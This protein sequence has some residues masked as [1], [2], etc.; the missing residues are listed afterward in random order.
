MIN[1]LLF[2]IFF[3]CED[4]QSQDQEVKEIDLRQR[5]RIQVLATQSFS[6][7]FVLEAKIE[8]S[9]YAVLVPK[10][11]GRVAEVYVRIGDVVAE[12]DVLLAVEEKDYLEG[13]R[14]AHEA[15]PAYP[16]PFQPLWVRMATRPDRVVVCQA[17]T[18]RP[19]R[20]RMS[21]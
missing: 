11:A 10:S 3:A 2:L 4:V 20:D 19:A 9:K 15:L 16:P 13:Y 21:R 7:E 6:Q 18:P 1:A 8:A 17:G 5:V 14:E 12:N